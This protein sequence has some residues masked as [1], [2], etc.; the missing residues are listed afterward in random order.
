MNLSEFTSASVFG[1]SK[2]TEYQ[3]VL[4]NGLLTH[5]P[6]LLR[7]YAPAHRYAVIS[8]HT[9]SGLYGDKVLELSLIHI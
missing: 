1:D 9:V 7:E 2:P 5:L 8:D 6:D 4:G 3:V